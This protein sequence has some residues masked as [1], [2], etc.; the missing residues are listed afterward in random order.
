[1]KNYYLLFLIAIVTCNK[2]KEQHRTIIDLQGI[3]QFSLDTAN[4]GEDQRWYLSNLNDSIKLPGTTDLNQKGFLNLD[5]TT[6]HLNRVYKYEGVA[7]YQKK[8]VIPENFKDKHI[9]LILERTKS[10]KIWVDSTFIGASKLLQSSQ[11]FDVTNYLSPGEHIITIQVNN[12]LKLTPYGEV[13]IYSDHTQTNW[14][15]IIG[16]LYLEASSKTFISNLQAYP[17]IDKQKVDVELEIENLPNSE[18]LTIELQMELS[19]N[20]KTIELKSQKFDNTFNSKVKLAYLFENNCSLWNEY[21]QPIYRLAAII[22]NE[23]FKDSKEINFGMRKFSTE[24]TQFKVN[25]QTVFLRGKH[26][27]SIFPLTGFAP[28]NVEDW[29]RVYKIAKS[30]GINHYRFHTYCPPEAAFTAADQVGMYLQVEL[31]LWNTLDTILASSLKDEGIAMLKSY[32]NHPSFVM[33]AHGNELW[34]D[35]QLIDKNIKTFKEY[36][37]RPLYSMGSNNGLGSYGP[38][39]KSDFHVTVHTPYP[40]DSI[41]SHVRLVHCFSDSKDGGIINTQTPSSVRNFNYPISQIKVPLVS[42]EIGQYQVYPNYREIKKYTGVL[43]AR[44]LEVFRGRLAKASMLHLDSAFSKAS[45]TWAAIC[46]KAEM[47]AAFRTKGM[48]GFQLLDLQDYSGQGTALVGVLDA[49][50]DS[51]NVVTPEI[52]KQ[53][54]NDIVLLLEFPKFCYTNKEKV[55]AKI[56]VANYSNKSISNDLQWEVRKQDGSILMQNAQPNIEIKNGGL[57]DAR[58]IV[59]DLSAISKAEKLSV[60][61]SIKG[62]EYKNSYPIWVYPTSAK[63]ELA[64]NIII[65]K[66]LNSQVLSQLNNGASVLLFPQDEDVKNNSYKGLF[67]PD[68][69]NYGMFKGI[70]EWQKKPVSPGTMG[71]LT[72]PTHPIFRDFP[73]D[74]HTN[75]QWFSIIKA[76]NSLIIDQTSPNYFPIV[77]VIDNLERNHKLGLI[78]EFKVGQGKLL[79]CMSQLLNI[80]DKPEAA[81]LY[82]SIIN[83]MNSSEFAPQYEVDLKKL[84]LN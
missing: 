73:T 40:N 36:D 13:H 74:F 8:I 59:I 66:K 21:E 37:P 12:N 28:T 41:L 56:V 84:N 61:I 34:T 71:I 20:G 35:I 38:S 24:G 70:S 60:N 52:W 63:I 69:W 42:H 2:P 31:P 29:L 26:D 54:C 43:R 82:Q 64:N 67:N 78:F 30:Y 49:F 23:N 9:Q 22:S 46:Y 27:G 65:A 80:M 48:A 75:W 45:G 32:A 10:T 1:M 77:Q 39:A 44:N 55:E 19:I 11:L 81:Q 51:K 6:M 7:W 5:T 18:K 79:V 33:F 62:T 47:E 50:M 83:Y 3:W 14:N 72:N 17:D 16:N 57:F 68:F 15:G 76:S 53:S 25:G 4:I 58:N